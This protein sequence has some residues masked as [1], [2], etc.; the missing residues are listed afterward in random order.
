[1]PRLPDLMY[2]VILK[3]MLD[4]TLATCDKNPVAESPHEKVT[5]V[6]QRKYRIKVMRGLSNLS[7]RD[8]GLP[9]KDL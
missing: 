2:C 7:G 4:D 8:E 1:M 6:P 5:L 3:V 9:T